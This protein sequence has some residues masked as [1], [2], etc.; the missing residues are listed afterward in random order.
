M[1]PF[2]HKSLEKKK[3]EVNP[4]KIDGKTSENK[5]KKRNQN[6]NE[7]INDLILEAL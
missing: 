1:C 6:E 7:N 5:Q 4:E 2:Q 3:D